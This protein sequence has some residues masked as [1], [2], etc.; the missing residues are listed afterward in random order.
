MTPDTIRMDDLIVNCIIGTKPAE[1]VTRQN[2]AVNL[3]LECDLAPAGSSDRI[4]DTVNYVDLKD[5]IVRMAEES[6]C[7]LIEAL[8]ARIADLCLEDGRIAAV[9]VD[10]AKP[11]AL[12]CARSVA[13]RIRRT[14]TERSP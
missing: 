11:G 5:R 7:F 12:T 13:V 3:L 2:V 1:R 9:T 14:S 10:V 4:E 6:E 8:A